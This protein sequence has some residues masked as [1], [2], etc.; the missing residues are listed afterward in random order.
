MSLNCFRLPFFKNNV[1]QLNESA[2]V[3][4]SIECN[5]TS[6]TTAQLIFKK[7]NSN[8]LLKLKG[9]YVHYIDYNLLHR[10]SI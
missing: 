4:R 2:S 9:I 6:I 5:P 1:D 10:N 8:E 7:E 3:N